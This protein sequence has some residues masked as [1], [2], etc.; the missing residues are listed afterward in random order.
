MKALQ[1]S[2]AYNLTRAHV[3]VHVHACFLTGHTLQVKA[4]LFAPPGGIKL[5]LAF[6]AMARK[7]ASRIDFGEVTVVGSDMLR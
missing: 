4:M 5:R 2:F 6:R 1:P 7:F 3:H